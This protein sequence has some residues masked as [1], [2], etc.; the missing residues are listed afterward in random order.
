MG[1]LGSQGPGGLSLVRVASQSQHLRA[2][3]PLLPVSRSHPPT[4]LRH[5]WCHLSIYFPRFQKKTHVACPKLHSQ[6]RGAQ[7]PTHARVSESHEGENPVADICIFNQT[8]NPWLKARLS[9]SGKDRMRLEENRGVRGTRKRMEDQG[10]PEWLKSQPRAFSF[11]P[12]DQRPH[13]EATPGC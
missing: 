11:H 8:Q 2:Q 4:I 1:S 9:K 10:L 13:A 5:F 6:Q 3:P 7:A 12:G